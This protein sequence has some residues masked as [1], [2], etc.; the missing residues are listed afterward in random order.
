MSAHPELSVIIVHYHT[1][2]LLRLCLRSLETNLKDLAT[3]IFVIDSAAESDTKETLAEEFPLVKYQP[4]QANLGYAAGVNHG[5]KQASG[6]YLLIL[7]PD[8]II[9]PGAVQAM[10]AHLKT[11][12]QVGLLGPKLL[13]F[14]GARQNSCFRFYRPLTIVY[15]RTFLGLLPFAKKALAKFN[16][17]GELST[18]AFYPDW[19]MGSALLTTRDAVAK[20][21]PMDESYFLYFEDVDWAHRFWENGYQVAYLPSVE[22]FHYHQRRSRAGL[23]ALD[24]ILRREARWHVRSGLKY[25]HKY[26]LQYRSGTDLAKTAHP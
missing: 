16:Y 4:H 7:N 2:E 5:L 13:D 21:G 19:L 23:D 18:E 14:S 22:V 10:L 1:P 17:Q 6:Q 11:H 25:F 26:G 8:I 3:E 15:R 9:K 24:F 20:V 12:P